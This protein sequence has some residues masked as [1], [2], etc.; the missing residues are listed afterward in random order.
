MIRLVV[1][2]SAGLNF[3]AKI[4][5]RDERHDDDDLLLEVE[6]EL[7]YYCD[8]L[9]CCCCPSKVESR[10]SALDLTCGAK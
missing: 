2:S 8:L 7:D 4:N 5:Q 10:A 3:A 6:H 9:F 1:S